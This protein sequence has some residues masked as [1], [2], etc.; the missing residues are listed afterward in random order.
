MKGVVGKVALGEADAGFV[1]V[2]DVTPVAGKV[3]A[4][5]IP[6]WA[7]PT[8]RYEIAV[9]SARAATRPRRARSWRASLGKLRARAAFADAGFRQP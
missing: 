5:A 6:A 3:T 4:I 7:Q 2:T 8:V 1:Y 9:V